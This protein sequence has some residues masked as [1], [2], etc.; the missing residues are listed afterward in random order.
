MEEAYIRL[1]GRIDAT[2]EKGF[3]RDILA[4]REGTLLYL[5]VNSQGGDL[6][7][8][9]RMSSLLIEEARKKDLLT[10][11]VGHGAVDSA[12]IR[13]FMSCQIRLGHRDTTYLLHR[14][15]AVAVGV[16]D[17]KIMLVTRHEAKFISH[18]AGCSY[19]EILSLLEKG[20]KIDSE[21]AERLGIT[22]APS[23]QEVGQMA[24]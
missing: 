2:V 22:N 13:V 1:N 21:C 7:S 3:R 16:S 24:F 15:K 5:H 14:P 10:V 8:A 9:R 18:V 11:G 12:A 4:L 23:R 19:D 17:E 6:G 20:Q